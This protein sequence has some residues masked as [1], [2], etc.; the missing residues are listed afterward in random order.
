MR[1]EA[2][3]LETKKLLSE[4]TKFKLLD[5][6]CL[7]GGT[8]LALQIGHRISVDLDWFARKPL[9]KNLLKLL[10]EF[11]PKSK[12]EVDV[13]KQEELTVRINGVQATFFYY[14]F[15]WTEQPKK[16][17]NFNLATIL[18]IAAMKAQT[19]N[20]RAAF[21]DYVDL[22]YILKQKHVELNQ[23]LNV[24]KKTF[25]EEFNK[26]LFLEQLVFMEDIAESGV[27]FLNPK[28]TKTE[29]QNFFESLVKTVKL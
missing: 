1:Y 23:L 4:L 18:Q 9:P 20:R 27:N 17:E 22:Y 25:A 26:R 5:N 24:A 14:P 3:T 16:Q 11:L 13:L 6:F 12:I 19:I 21:K 15:S 29:I 28:V 7:V 10:Q 2:I 8:A